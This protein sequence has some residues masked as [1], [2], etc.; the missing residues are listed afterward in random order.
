MSEEAERL[1]EV[2]LYTDF[3]SPYAYLAFDPVM[4]LESKY[5]VKIAWKPFQLRLKGKGQRSVYSEY[6]VKYSYMDA[7]RWANLRGGL[8]LRGPLKIFD[9]TPALIGSLFAE[10]HGKLVEYGRMVYEAF[11][12]RELAADEAD[13]IAGVL[14]R[15]GLDEAAFRDFLAGEGAAEYE[16]I[17]EES[18]ADEIFGV[19]IMVLDGEKFWGYDRI[20]LL[21]MRLKDKGL[22]RRP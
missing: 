15:L 6:K 21:E 2:K 4:E 9:T 22:E 8:M 18:T 5:W 7:R 10:R 16:R 20:G 19:P 17:Q 14:M 12:K 3:K 11:F 1:H 13:A